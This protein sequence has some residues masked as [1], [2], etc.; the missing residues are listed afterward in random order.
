MLVYVCIYRVRLT[1]YIVREKE[2]VNIFTFFMEERHGFGTVCN[3][4]YI[5]FYY[6]YNETP[7]AT[8][9]PPGANIF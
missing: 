6:Y 8:T 7:L 9:S 2:R 5:F 4:C 1:I 3:F